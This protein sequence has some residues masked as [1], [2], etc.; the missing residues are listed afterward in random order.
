[1]PFTATHIAAILPFAAW[2]RLQLPFSALAI[3]AMIPD[4]PMF[5]PLFASYDATHSAWGILAICFPLGLLVLWTFQNLMKQPLCLL[6][7][8]KI[9]LRLG[10]LAKPSWNWSPGFLARATLALILGAS[11]HILWDSFTHHDRWGTRQWA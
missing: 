8:Q 10:K 7:P 9:T 3:G 4:Y 5:V 2:R 6:L 1:M 11:T